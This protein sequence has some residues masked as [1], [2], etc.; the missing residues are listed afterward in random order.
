MNCNEI[1]DMMT[2]YID[3]ELEDKEKKIFEEHIE[4]CEGCRKELEDYK[5]I[6]SMLQNMTEEDPPKGY[7]NRLHEKLL[8][9]KA[10][11]KISVRSKWMKYGSIAA[12][13][14]LV[15]SAVYV[16]SITDGFRGS[17]NKKSESN[18]SY[19]SLMPATEPSQAQQASP[20]MGV[21]DGGGSAGVQTKEFGSDS[22][23][24]AKS[25]TNKIMA[26]T[27]EPAGS[28]EKYIKI[29]KSG[30]IYTETEAYDTFTDELISKVE[31]LGGYFEQ[32]NTSVQ[33]IYG[34]RKLKYGHLIIRIP[35][36][37]FYEFVS[38]LEESS[39]VNQKNVTES[40]ATKVYY[41]KDNQVKNLELQESHLR[42]LFVK[43]QTVQDMLLIENELRRIRT[44]ID[45]LN[46][47]LKDI[48][49]RSSM[50]TI[51]LEVQEVLKAN[52][53]LSDGD[54]VWD[55][56]REGFINTVNGI[57]QMGENFVIMIISFS[58]LLVPVVIIFIVV[59]FKLRKNKK[60]L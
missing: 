27:V 9:A 40:D 4:D 39:D 51:S 21:M 58:P 41:E 49:D 31:M 20:E 38:Y 52:L 16:A 48:D 19:D 54:S 15:I 33:S 10:K 60:R 46:I 32:N 13:F 22:K 3:G 1:K 23:N 35:Q 2:L 24:Y 37:K 8:K 42:E 56:A 6:I 12:I 57:V 44:E 11:S 18:T 17:K 55:R 5:K 34:D 53:N 25:E 7:C 14:V 45:A 29:I 26:E 43:A 36:D 30:S 28:D 50:S 59:F 47:S